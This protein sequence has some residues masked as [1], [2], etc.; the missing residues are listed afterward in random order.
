MGV[1]ELRAGVL[2]LWDASS[3]SV[4]AV[5]VASVEARLQRRRLAVYQNFFQI[6]DGDHWWYLAGA[7]ATKYARSATRALA[8]R[9]EVPER[10]PQPTGM[11]MHNYERLI[12]NPTTHQMVWVA[13]WIE[14]LDRSLIEA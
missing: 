8:E 7:V 13:C 4:F 1:L 5:P 9:Y 3:G 12:K 10:A 2:S 14:A 6:H 11:T